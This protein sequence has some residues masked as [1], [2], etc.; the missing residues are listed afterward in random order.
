[1]L[2]VADLD[3]S[4]DFYQRLLQMK[5]QERHAN[6]TRQTEVALVGYG[7][8][9]GP[10][11]ELTKDTSSAAPAVVPLSNHIGI[12]VPDL[13][14]LCTKLEEEG[15]SFARPFKERGDGK[16]VT[17][18]VRDPDGHSIELVELYTK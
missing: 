5:V 14:G 12:H 18:W 8:D 1:M 6:T 10:F 13:R 3:R 11:L 2:P 15:V 9:T 17:A 4:V 7:R 16:G